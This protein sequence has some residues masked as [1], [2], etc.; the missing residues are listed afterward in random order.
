MLTVRKATRSAKTPETANTHA[1]CWL[2]VTSQ[3]IEAASVATVAPR[4][5]AT[6]VIGIAQHSKVPEVVNNS[7][8]F[9][10]WFFFGESITS[11]A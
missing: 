11:A 4:P 8:Q 10:E 5:R 6:K 9:H 2:S 7:S 1:L 3:G